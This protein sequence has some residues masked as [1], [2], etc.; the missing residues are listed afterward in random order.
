M[1]VSRQRRASPW[2]GL[3]KITPLK[4]HKNKN[5]TRKIFI[6][7]ETICVAKIVPSKTPQK[8]PL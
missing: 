1:K 6:A 8:N 3:G 4:I 7:K 2:A 5:V